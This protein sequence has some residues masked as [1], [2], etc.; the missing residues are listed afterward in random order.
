MIKFTAAFAAGALMFTAGLSHADDKAKPRAASPSVSQ[1]C[2]MQTG[3]RIPVKR[4][5]CT[6][7]GRSYSKDEILKTG[8]TTAADALRL[9]D[10]SI[11]I[12]R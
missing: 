1:A 10:P 3:S 12:H 5:E 6:R 9:L 11:T 8:A 2:V 7:P 4:K